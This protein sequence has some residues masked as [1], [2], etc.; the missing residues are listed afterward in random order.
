MERFFGFRGLVLWS[1]FGLNL[2]PKHHHQHRR[3]ATNKHTHPETRNRMPDWLPIL[4]GSLDE[5]FG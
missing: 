5:V 4:P 1:V 2:L 3:P